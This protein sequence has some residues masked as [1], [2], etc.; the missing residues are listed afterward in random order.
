[1]D[2]SPIAPTW[3]VLPLAMIALV[4]QAGYLMSLKEIPKGKIPESRRRIRIATGWLIM[5]AIPLSAYGFGIATTRDPSTF[6][7]VWIMIIA[8]ISGILVLAGLDTINTMRLHR[9]SQ[10]TLKQ[11]FRETLGVDRDRTGTG[12]GTGSS[13]SSSSSSSKGDHD[14]S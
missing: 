14:G 5:F 13:S 9:K 1:M 4:A 6:A 11:E 8:L 12:A 2:T 3:I 10:R 7:L